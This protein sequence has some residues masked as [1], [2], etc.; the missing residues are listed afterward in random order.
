MHYLI[1]IQYWKKQTSIYLQ[2]LMP[3]SFRKCPPNGMATAEEPPT[4]LTHK[5]LPCLLKPYASITNSS[6]HVLQYPIL[7]SYNWPSFPP[8][9]LNLTHINFLYKLFFLLKW[10]N[11]F[12]V[13]LFTRS[14]TSYFTPFAPHATCKLVSHTYTSLENR[15]GWKLVRQWVM[16]HQYRQNSGTL[17]FLFFHNL[18]LV[19]YKFSDR[20]T[21]TSSTNF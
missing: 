3:H 7:L 19:L 13:I 16:I 17:P 5:H 15:F 10:L 2:F 18:Q 12:K 8:R 4:L 11:H 9:L 20:N 1:N 21:D 14:T 6:I